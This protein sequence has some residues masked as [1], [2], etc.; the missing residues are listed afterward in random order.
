MSETFFKTLI[1]IAIVVVLFYLVFGSIKKM[2]IMEGLDNINSTKSL[3]SS[4]VTGET[5]GAASYTAQIKA[6]VIRLQD[7]LLISKYRKEY[8]AAIINLDDLINFSMLKLALDMKMDI[9]K[10]MTNIEKINTL[11]NGKASL[12]SIMKFLDKQ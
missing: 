11:C 8:E 1:V 2:K 9:N 12:N 3:T 7:S 5:S 6:E 4:I 10:D